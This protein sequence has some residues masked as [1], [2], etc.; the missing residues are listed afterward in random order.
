MTH[1]SHVNRF[2]QVFSLFLAYLVATT[3]MTA[4]LFPSDSEASMDNL[5]K[6]SDD[7]RDLQLRVL[8]NPYYANAMKQL[9][10][11]WEQKG[12]LDFQTEF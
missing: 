5:F 7:A 2:S 6:S 10:P 3:V 8:V 11:F 1:F 4:V 12:V 9:F